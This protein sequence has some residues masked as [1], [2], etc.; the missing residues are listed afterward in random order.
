V[1]LVKDT[2]I[3][4]QISHHDVIVGVRIT[5]DERTAIETLAKA[6]NQTVSEWIR[7]KI[8]AAM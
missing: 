4:F 6:K 8:N 1:P 7:E 2:V 5:T 3:G